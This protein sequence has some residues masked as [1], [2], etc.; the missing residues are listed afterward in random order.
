[1]PKRKRFVILA[2]HSK[3]SVAV[4]TREKVPWRNWSVCGLVFFNLGWLAKIHSEKRS[5]LRQKNSK[6]VYPLSN[7]VSNSQHTYFS[8]V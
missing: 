6:T 3:L 4:L 5:A 8:Q 7:R 1:M 2:L